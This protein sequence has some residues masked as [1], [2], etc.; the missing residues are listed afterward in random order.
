M[1][2]MLFMACVLGANCAEWPGV[3]NGTVKVFFHPAVPKAEAELALSVLSGS[4][5]ESKKKLGITGDNLKVT[6]RIYRTV[7]DYVAATGS[8]TFF[9]ATTTKDGVM[10]IQPVPVLNERGVLAKVLGHEAAHACLR[11]AGG[12]HL[13][14]WFEEGLSAVLAGEKPRRNEE[15]KM[16]TLAEITGCFATAAPKKKIE[17]CYWAV[18][19]AARRL[20]EKSGW[21]AVSKLLPALKD[22]GILEK[23]SPSAL[24]YGVE[25]LFIGSEK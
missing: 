2:I 19:E 10:H 8:S 1:S 20:V 11:E 24:G 5:T 4:L 18:E 15:W 14:R 7:A 17:Y 13:P 25:E 21:Q 22:G 23:A 9:G 16:P 6:A 12:K 3:Q